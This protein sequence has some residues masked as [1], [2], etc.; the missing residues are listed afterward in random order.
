VYPPGIE[1]KNTV[2]INFDKS[3]DRVRF[4]VTS[5]SREVTISFKDADLNVLGSIHRIDPGD[6]QRQT[7]IVHDDGGLGRIRHAEIRSLEVI[8]LDSFK[9]RSKR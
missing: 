7:L 3:W 5:A 1:N 9:F 6:V 4:A 8:R 2:F